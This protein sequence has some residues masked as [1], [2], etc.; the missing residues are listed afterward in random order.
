MDQLKQAL[1]DDSTEKID[2]LCEQLA[3]AAHRLT[4]SAYQQA[5]PQNAQSAGGAGSNTHA[6]PSK[7]Q[8]DVVDA[9]Y[10]EVA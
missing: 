8:E 10:E 7:G 5:G 9:E 3:Q 4:E 2:R 1:K 6:R